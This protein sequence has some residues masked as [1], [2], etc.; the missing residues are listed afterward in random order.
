MCIGLVGKQKQHFS[1]SVYSKCI[2]MLRNWCDNVKSELSP[3]HHKT[4]L[5][6]K[7]TKKRLAAKNNMN[8]GM[9]VGGA[10]EVGVDIVHMQAHT[11]GARTCKW[12]TYAASR[13]KL[14]QHLD[15]HREFNCPLSCG[16]YLE[17][18]VK[19]KWHHGTVQ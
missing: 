18:S 14:G 3:V 13:S 17:G 16:L 12:A 15:R 7:K 6:R 5:L 11:L 4:S 10:P 8:H 1:F 2:E 19:E 9:S